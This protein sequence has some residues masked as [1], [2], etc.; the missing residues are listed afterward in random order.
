MNRPDERP[1]LSGPA[2]WAA[3]RSRAKNAVKSSESSP[4][5]LLRQFVYT[6]LLARVF[7]SEPAQG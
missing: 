2:M 7:S 4:H 3:V 6:R 5:D 1:Y